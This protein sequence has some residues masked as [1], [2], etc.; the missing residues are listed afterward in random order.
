MGYPFIY[1]APDRNRTCTPKDRDLN[2]T[3]LPVPP[4]AHI[5]YTNSF[6]CDNQNILFFT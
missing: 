1:G 6:R 2:P 5:Y 4:R 3:R